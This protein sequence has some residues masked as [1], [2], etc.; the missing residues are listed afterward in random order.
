MTTE[1]LKPTIT[2]PRELFERMEGLL[3]DYFWDRERLN[4]PNDAVERVRDEARAALRDTPE[5]VGVTKEEIVKMV[6][7][8]YDEL[9]VLRGALN[10]SDVCKISLAVLN[11][12]REM[13]MKG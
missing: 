6:A 1:P 7:K 2:I 9:E 3:N 12:C 5:K 8:M 13:G 4:Q 10:Y 11:L